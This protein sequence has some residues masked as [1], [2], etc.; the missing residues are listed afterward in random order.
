MRIEPAAVLCA[1][2]A[3]TAA[4]AQQR[5]LLLPARDA[6]VT[7]RMTDNKDHQTAD[8]HA[9]FKAGGGL[10]RVDPPGAP[11]YMILDRNAGQVTTV[12]PEQHSYFQT[13]MGPEDRWFM[14]NDQMQFSRQGTQT[15]AGQTCTDWAMADAEATGTACVTDDGVLLRANGTGKDGSSGG[16]EATSVS[17]GDQPD[18]LFAVPAGFRHVAPPQPGPNGAP[19]RQ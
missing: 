2:L 9:Y 3:T 14:L 15:V 7:Y 17:L 4:H 13:K 18:S 12:I 11:F 5:P 16:M 19:R 1:L 6:A 10:M 8:M